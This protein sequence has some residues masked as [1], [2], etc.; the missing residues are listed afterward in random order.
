MS[1][2]VQFDGETFV[3]G[4]N[5][6]VYVINVRTHPGS[7]TTAAV[8]WVTKGDKPRCIDCQGVTVAMSA[9]CKHA[10]AVKRALASGKLGAAMSDAAK[11][12]EAFTN[13][14]LPMGWGTCGKPASRIRMINGQAWYLCE[15]CSQG[16]GEPIEEKSGISQK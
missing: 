3:G 6:T 5:E 7:A 4:I 1:L 16:N 2:Y 15:S 10:Q 12:C 11:R 9:S 14:H 8:V 13:T